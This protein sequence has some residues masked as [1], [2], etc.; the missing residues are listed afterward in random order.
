MVLQTGG[1]GTSPLIILPAKSM[2]GLFLSMGGDT[3][4]REVTQ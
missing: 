3:I 2:K 4:R 1:G